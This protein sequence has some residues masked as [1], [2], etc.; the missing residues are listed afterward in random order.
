MLDSI[1]HR[2]RNTCCNM[3]AG[4]KRRR[5]DNGNISTATRSKTRRISIKTERPNKTRV[6]MRI[7]RARIAI[8]TR[9][10]SIRIKHHIN[11]N[12]NRDHMA[13]TLG[14][15]VEDEVS[16]IS[17]SSTRTSTKDKINTSTVPCWRILGLS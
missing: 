17:S 8:P 14:I 1:H 3:L 9:H 16:L 4:C 2:L 6:F 11:N 13:E 12:N 7:G 15:V 5:T 10:I